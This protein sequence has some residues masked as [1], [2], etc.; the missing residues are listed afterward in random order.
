MHDPAGQDTH[1]RLCTKKMDLDKEGD[2]H[3]GV[4]AGRGP[5][6]GAQLGSRSSAPLNRRWGR[7]PA[8]GSAGKMLAGREGACGAAHD[9][10]LAE[11]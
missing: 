3:L 1:P 4:W 2:G 10:L 11:I 6:A 8:S 9:P 7:A 5:G